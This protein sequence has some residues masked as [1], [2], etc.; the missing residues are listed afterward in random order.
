M[1]GA[2]VA[3]A[4]LAS[5]ATATDQAAAASNLLSAAREY[6]NAEEKLVAAMIKADENYVGRNEIAR[7]VDG[8]Y[9]RRTVQ[10]LLS[11]AELIQRSAKA[12]E[13]HGLTGDIR[14][15]QGT[16]RRL[17]MVLADMNRTDDARLQT[18]QAT[19]QALAKAGIDAR[20]E[21]SSRPEEHLAA[22]KVLELVSAQRETRRRR[23]KLSTSR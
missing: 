2:A 1:M 23:Q 8:I 7:R 6:R 12:L 15:W 4:L 14:F 16:K 9:A 20:G 18:S 13:E 17:L 11:S 10:T 19:V 22:G 5:Q 3:A 21:G